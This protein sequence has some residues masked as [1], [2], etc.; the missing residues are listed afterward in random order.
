METVKDGPWRIQVISHGKGGGGASFAAMPEGTGVASFTLNDAN[1]H[2]VFASDFV[3]TRPPATRI[4]LNGTM[5]SPGLFSSAVRVRI[6]TEDEWSGVSSLE[7]RFD[8]GPWIAYFDAFLVSSEGRHVLEVRA[9]D[10]AG[11]VGVESVAFVIDLNPFSV[12]GPLDGGPTILAAISGVAVL[13]LLF[14]VRY[15]A[16]RVAAVRTGGSA[17]RGRDPSGPRLL[18]G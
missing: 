7:Y 10:G 1:G 8:G 15:D 11:N 5:E 16:P 14:W 17:H 4:F 9:T 13:G 6:E 18:Y 2:L 3:D 12:S